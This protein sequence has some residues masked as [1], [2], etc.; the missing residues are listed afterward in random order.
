MLIKVYSR[1]DCRDICKGEEVAF[2]QVTERRH[3]RN[4]LILISEL[5]FCRDF[6]EIFLI[7]LSGY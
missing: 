3:L 7:F 4:K 1:V 5:E 2:L 6:L